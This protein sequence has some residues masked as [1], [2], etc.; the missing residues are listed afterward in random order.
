[1]RQTVYTGAINIF[2]VYLNFTSGI[3]RT[4]ADETVQHVPEETEVIY[5]VVEGGS[6]TGRN[7]LVSSDGYAFVLKRTLAN[8]TVDWRCSVRHNGS[9]C[10]AIIKQSGTEFRIARSSHTHSSKPGLLT[11]IQIKAEVSNVATL[12]VTNWYSL[13]IYNVG[14]LFFVSLT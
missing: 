8:G 14:K 2:S 3:H 4:I 13:S 9:G 7:K 11:A 1:M 12:N 6:G 5:H 10:L